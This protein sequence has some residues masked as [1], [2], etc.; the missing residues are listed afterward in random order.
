MNGTEPIAEKTAREQPLPREL[1]A[2]ADRYG[3]DLFDA[4]L[5]I[6]GL[7][8]AIDFMLSQ[9]RRHPHL[10]RLHPMIDA[11]AK[12]LADLSNALI[13][14][15]GWHLVDVT[16]CIGE[17]GKAQRVIAEDGPRVIVP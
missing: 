15:K 1:Q 3:R 7:T 14:A 8:A 16:D 11:I 9:S 12:G 5:C 10:A 4:A 17:I 2:V 13:E 6:A